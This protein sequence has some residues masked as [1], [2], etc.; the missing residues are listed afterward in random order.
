MQVVKF[1]GAC[2]CLI[3]AGAFL[4]VGHMHAGLPVALA[5]MSIALLSDSLSKR[6]NYA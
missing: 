1:I 2:L 4:I 5:L 6:M 3:A